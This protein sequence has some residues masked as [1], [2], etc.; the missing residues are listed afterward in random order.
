MRVRFNMLGG[1][2]PVK[3]YFRNMLYLVERFNLV[4]SANPDIIIYDH[5]SKRGAFPNTKKK[6]FI[7]TESINIDWAFCSMGCSWRLPENVTRQNDY[8][9]LTSYTINGAG[10]DLIKP[11]DYAVKVVPT[12]TKF[13]AFVYSNGAPTIRATFFNMLSKYKHVDA[14]GSICNNMRPIGGHANTYESRFSGAWGAEKVEFF[15]P[16][17]FVIAFEN[18][19]HPG[20]TDEKIYHAMKA[21]CIPIYWGNPMVHRDFNMAS[22]IS[23]YGIPGNTKKRLQYLIDQIE[24]IDTNDHAYTRVL[25]SPWYHGNRLSEW[26]NPSIL[27]NKFRKVFE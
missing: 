2:I 23:P 24:H 6:V 5:P 11:S 17:K 12:K 20:Y 25:N 3:T 27:T 16:Y 19:E 10:E 18:E 26:V 9:R 14:P 1:Q 13:C 8:I 7:S 21:G 15:K 4:D 22:F